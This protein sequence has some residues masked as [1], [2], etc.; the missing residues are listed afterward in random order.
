MTVDP[1]AISFVIPVFNVADY[2]DRCMSSV[3]AQ[4]LPRGT[5]E[6]IVV[7]DG[8][9]DDSLAIAQRWRDAYPEVRVVTQPNRGVSAARNVGLAL[10]TGAYIWFVDSDD[11]ISRECVQTL[12]RHCLES[13]LDLVTFRGTRLKSGSPD[14]VTFDANLDLEDVQNGISYIAQYNYNNSS[15]L[16][17]VRRHYIEGQSLTFKEGRRLED[18]MLTLPLVSNA[19]KVAHYSSVAYAYVDNVETF[20]S[21]RSPSHAAKVIEDFRYAIGFFAR[22]IEGQV[23]YANPSALYLQRVRSRQ[24]S[25][26]FFLCM[27][28]LGFPMALRE[29]LA[30]YDDLRLLGYLPLVHL[31][32]AEYPGAR[33]RLLTP[34]VNNRLAFK[35]TASVLWALRPVWRSDP[36]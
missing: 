24:D 9:T 19:G 30:I 2:L 34:L 4:N 33:Y 35:A 17:L 16:Y 28:L 31:N 6:V 32:R 5:Y 23:R 18:G 3:V 14:S 12:L 27:R 21:S 13:N 10:A 11:F 1:M 7:D 25:Y 36:R 26:T 8:S 20:T 22:F 29:S 15:C